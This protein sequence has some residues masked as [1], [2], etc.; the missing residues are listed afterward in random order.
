[1]SRRDRRNASTGIARLDRLAKL[2]S[3]ARA[4]LCQKLGFATP[5]NAEGNSSATRTLMRGLPRFVA[6]LPNLLP[7]AYEFEMTLKHAP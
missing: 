3:S 6:P 2:A 1:M 7:N 4:N 5:S